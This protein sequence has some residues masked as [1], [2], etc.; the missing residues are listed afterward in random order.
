MKKQLEGTSNKILKYHCSPA[1]QITQISLLQLYGIV[2]TGI[3]LFLAQLQKSSWQLGRNLEQRESYHFES[4][5]FLRPLTC[6]FLY[7]TL[8]DGPCLGTWDEDSTQYTWLSYSQVKN[9]VRGN[10]DVMDSK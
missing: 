9:S 3:A 1:N 4:K 2:P 5:I 10:V 8:D 6:P 7:F